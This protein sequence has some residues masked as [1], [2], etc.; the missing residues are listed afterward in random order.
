M[1]M[2]SYKKRYLILIFCQILDDNTLRNQNER[3]NHLHSSC[4]KERIFRIWKKRDSQFYHICL[5]TKYK[6]ISFLLP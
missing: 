1:Y 3:F 5:R 2:S 4:V 6:L